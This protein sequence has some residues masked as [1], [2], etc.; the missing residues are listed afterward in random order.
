MI[1]IPDGEEDVSLEYLIFVNTNLKY[2][3]NKANQQVKNKRM[4]S[5]NR[6]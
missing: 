2:S 3:L 4:I 1:T 5:F 6:A